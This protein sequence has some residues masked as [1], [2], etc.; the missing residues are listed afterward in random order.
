MLSSAPHL[1]STGTSSGGL[2]CR[3]LDSPMS[4][5]VVDAAAAAMHGGGG[6]WCASSDGVQLPRAGLQE[7]VIA[8]AAS[9]PALRAASPRRP[10]N[11]PSSSSSDC[12]E[13]AISVALLQLRNGLPSARG[14]VSAKCWRCRSEFG[15]AARAGGP[16]GVRGE[17]GRSGTFRGLGRRSAGTT[18]HC[19]DHNHTCLTLHQLRQ[20]E[21]SS[22]PAP[23]QQGGAGC[24]R[25]G[26]HAGA[27]PHPPA[28]AAAGGGVCRTQQAL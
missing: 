26:A 10:T 17:I 23:E 22:P 6:R 7:P 4:L 13:L 28:R 27:P 24:A 2:F 9:G 25:G 15:A 11:A 18:R 20:P 21:V 5:P 8:A 3:Y 16:T 1:S 19:E 12:S 14:D